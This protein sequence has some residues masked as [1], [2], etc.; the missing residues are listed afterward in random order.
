MTRSGIFCHSRHNITCRFSYRFPTSSA[1]LAISG[2]VEG[3]KILL[4]L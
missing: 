3:L 1:E 4:D 2:N